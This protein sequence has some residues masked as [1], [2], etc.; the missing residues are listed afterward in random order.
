MKASTEVQI[1]LCGASDV[2]AL[3]DLAGQLG[4]PS[5]SSQIAARLSV[6]LESADHAILVAT[7]AGSTQPIGFAH[8][9]VRR[10]LVDDV[11]VELAALVIDERHRGRGCG[12]SLLK[13]AEQWALDRGI[14][15][16]SLRSNVIRTAAHSFYESLGY[17]RVKTSYAFR[18]A[19]S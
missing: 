6:L 8:V 5:T 15:S 7:A 17:D 18:K 1:R 12:K 4:Y 19:L 9:I 14:D 2:A 11:T 16:L 10:L 3:A 13:A